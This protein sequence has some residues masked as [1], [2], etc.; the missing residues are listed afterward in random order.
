MI[1]I[2]SSCDKI[3]FNVIIISIILVFSL[4]LL[5]R[6]ISIIIIIDNIIVIIHFV[7]LPLLLS[8]LALSLFVLKLTYLKGLVHVNLADTTWTIKLAPNY[9]NPRYIFPGGHSMKTS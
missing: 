2:I 9:P 8:L 4:S 6:N 1:I 7:I 3:L 5:P